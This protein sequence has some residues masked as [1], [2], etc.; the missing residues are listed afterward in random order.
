MKYFIFNICLIFVE[1]IPW[2]N[3]I[4]NLYLL[5]KQIVFIT[6]QSPVSCNIELIHN[7]IEELYS[8]YIKLFDKTL[9][10]KHHNMFHYVRVMKIVGPLVHIWLMRFEGKHCSLK[11]ST[12][13]PK[14]RINLPYTVANETITSFN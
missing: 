14:N 6:L 10:P 1:L 2:R 5:L 11:Q 9:K 7:F 12:S 13:T 8:L 3:K 4:W